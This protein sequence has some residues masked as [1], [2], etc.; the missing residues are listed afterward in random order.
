MKRH[1]LP[2]ALGT[3]IRTRRQ[4]LGLSQEDLAER[5]GLH[6]TYVGSVERGERNLTLN[7]IARIS[8]ALSV[9]PSRL[10]AEAEQQL[11]DGGARRG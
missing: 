4:A 8:E 9:P 5:C 2:R 7:N 11:V 6:R 1:A 3:V 10:L